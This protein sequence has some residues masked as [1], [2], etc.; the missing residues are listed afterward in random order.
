M[1]SGDAGCMVAFPQDPGQPRATSEA[2]GP[3]TCVFGGF[4]WA[5]LL[6]EPV[7]EGRVAALQ[8]DLG[9]SLAQQAARYPEDHLIPP[10]ARAESQGRDRPVV[11]H[12]DPHARLRE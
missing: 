11:A 1:G 7:L 12:L 9:L 5:Y 3:R 4:F 2:G 8:A 6:E 10:G